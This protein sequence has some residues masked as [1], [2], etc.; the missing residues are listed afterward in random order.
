MTELVKIQRYEKALQKTFGDSFR[1]SQCAV[2]NLKS[3]GTLE[4]Y[5]RCYNGCY[6]G[7]ELH[8]M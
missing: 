6:K 8:A 4:D 2:Y 3:H 1:M 7:W 5:N